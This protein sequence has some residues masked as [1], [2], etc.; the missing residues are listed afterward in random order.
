VILYHTLER[1]P[2][3]KEQAIIQIFCGGSSGVL[4]AAT[5]GGSLSRSNR[6]TLTFCELTQPKKVSAPYN[7]AREERQVNKYAEQ[8]P[9]DN[10]CLFQPCVMFNE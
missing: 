10:I 6:A 2:S 4:I 7:M 3:G 9:Q 8:I 5:S 1:F